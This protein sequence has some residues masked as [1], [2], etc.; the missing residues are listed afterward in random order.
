MVSIGLSIRRH[1]FAIKVSSVVGVLGVP[2]KS[3]G[4][5]S[6]FMVEDKNARRHNST[7]PFPQDTI[8]QQ[9]SE[10]MRGSFASVRRVVLSG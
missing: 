10:V 2:S 5:A 7:P 1:D 9:L 4:P 6:L 3:R 8:F